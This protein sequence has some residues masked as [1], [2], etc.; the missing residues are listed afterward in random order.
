MHPKRRYDGDAPSY[1][2]AP[3][4][5]PEELYIGNPSVSSLASVSSVAGPSRQVLHDE[6]MDLDLDDDSDEDDDYVERASTPSPER[7]RRRGLM[8]MAGTSS[9][10]ATAAMLNAK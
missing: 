3:G 10:R 6:P 2:S 8:R 7:E 9:Q 5:H 1:R 4:R